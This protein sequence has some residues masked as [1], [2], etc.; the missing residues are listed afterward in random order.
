L[1]EE[2]DE[3]NSGKKSGEESDVESGEDSDNYIIRDDKIDLN[4]II[5]S[6][7]LLNL[8]DRFFCKED[9]AGLCQK[10]GFDLNNGSCDCKAD[11]D[12]RLIKLAELL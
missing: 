1:S 12:P 8:D 5:L 6:E 3:K 2:S 7:L 4:E 9:C 11:I 10:C